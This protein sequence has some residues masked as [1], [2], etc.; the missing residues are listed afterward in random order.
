MNEDFKLFLSIIISFNIFLIGYLLIRYIIYYI[1]NSE[2]TNI[3]YR[4]KDDVL[5]YDALYLIL[6]IYIGMEIFTIITLIVF[7]ILNHIL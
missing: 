2:Y 3:Y 6:K 7:K 4:F 1:K 5:Q